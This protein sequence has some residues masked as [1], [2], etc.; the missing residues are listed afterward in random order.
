MCMETKCA[1][2]IYKREHTSIRE[3]VLLKVTTH[4]Q[5]DRLFILTLVRGRSCSVIGM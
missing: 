4:F 2:E 1:W 5:A 3:C